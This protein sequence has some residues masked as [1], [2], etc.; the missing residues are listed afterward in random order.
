MHELTFG[1]D[2]IEVV[3]LP[4]VGARLHRLRVFGN[5]LLRTPADP[6]VHVSDPFFWGAYPMAPWCGRVEAAPVVIGGKQVVLPPNFPDGTAIHGQVYASPWEVREDRSL[7][8]RAGGD[9]WPWPYEVTMRVEARYASVGLDYALTNLADEPMPAGIGVHPWFLRPLNVAIQARGVLTPNQ[10]TPPNAAPVSGPFDLRQLVE[11]P[12]DL[13]AT[14][15]DLSDPPVQLY[16]PELGI[17][18]TLRAE[19]PALYIVAASPGH[20][21]AVALEPQTHAP[22]AIRRLL[23]GEPGA[24]A[25]L[26]PGEALRLRVE[27]EFERAAKRAP[28]GP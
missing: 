24:L 9:A 5:D 22:Q 2:T 10:A 18:A 8:V 4:E 16:W 1:G 21:T 28:T 12:S 11:M 15:T 17:R 27:L 6:R 26:G 13:D 14:W 7:T 3:V 23:N 25:M 20:L 19:A